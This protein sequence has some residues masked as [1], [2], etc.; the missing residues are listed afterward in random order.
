[1]IRFL[2]ALVEDRRLALWSAGALAIVA[3]SAAPWVHVAS[4][5]RPLTEL[6]LDAGGKITI[7]CGAVALALVVAYV[8]LRARDLAAG[9][10]I[11]A[12]IAATLAGV[13]LLRVRDASSRVLARMLEVDGE[14]VRSEFA[15]RAG[16]GGWVVLAGAAA[17]IVAAAALLARRPAAAGEPD[18][19][20]VAG[21]NAAKQE[22]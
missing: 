14:A 4:P 21:T 20:L 2:A 1:M 15:A 3:G 9:A 22:P 7:L 17:V 11:A 5:L 10:A 18:S 12:A 13:Y 16:L 19:R 6:G 8:H